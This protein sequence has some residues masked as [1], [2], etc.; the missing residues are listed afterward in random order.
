MPGPGVP[1]EGRLSPVPR[2]P[3]SPLLRSYPGELIEGESDD[4]VVRHRS[5]ALAGGRVCALVEAGGDVVE[6]GVDAG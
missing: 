6:G 1:V 5:A 4:L 2:T 3:R